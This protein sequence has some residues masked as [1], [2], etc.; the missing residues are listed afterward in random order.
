M[1]VRPTVVLAHSDGRD[2]QAL[3]SCLQQVRGLLRSTRIIVLLP[4]ASHAQAQSEFADLD[5]EVAS[6][7]SDATALRL[8]LGVG[9]AAPNLLT[10]REVEVLELAALG[11]TNQAIAR[12]LGLQTNTVKN[13][14]RAVHRKFGARSRTEA[15]MI[16]AR[17]GYP[18]LPLR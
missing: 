17:A 15:V 5:V 18:V 1:R 13:Y 16:A 11:L 7:A 4:Q 12:R 6:D 2:L 14:L 8:L 10:R 9:F 3:Q